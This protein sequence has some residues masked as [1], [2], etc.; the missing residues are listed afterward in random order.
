M[1]LPLATVGTIL[2]FTMKP[3]GALKL[4]A[5]F[6]ISGEVKVFTHVIVSVESR[7]TISQSVTA[8]LNCAFVPL[9]VFDPRAIVL[10]VRTWLAVVPTI[11]CATFAG[12]Y[13]SLSSEAVGAG[14]V[15]G[16]FFLT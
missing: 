15:Q 14:K 12:S 13:V 9:T 3:S 1:R 8:V 6:V 7:N 10:F 16:V 5:P 2:P 4:I 11:C